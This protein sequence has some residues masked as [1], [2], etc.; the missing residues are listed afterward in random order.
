[1]ARSL[2]PQS[3]EIGAGFEHASVLPN[4]QFKRV[5]ERVQLSQIQSMDN[6]SDATDTLPLAPQQALWILFKLRYIDSLDTRF[7]LVISNPAIDYLD[8]YVLD[9]KNRI[10]DSYLVGSRR[11]NNQRPINHRN[12]I[13]PLEFEPAQ[14]TYIYAK[15]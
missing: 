7:A 5:D 6:W 12:F 1:M 8:V 15:S 4:A 10:L 2:E 9:D 13:L 3:M 11:D 14:S